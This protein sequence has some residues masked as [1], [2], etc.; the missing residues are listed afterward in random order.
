MLHASFKVA[1]PAQ[2]RPPNSGAGLVQVLASGSMPEP[3]VRE[4]GAVAL[5]LVHCPS[6]S[7]DNSCYGFAFK[8]H[9]SAY[10]VERVLQL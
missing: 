2:G 8:L 1:S 9:G 7:R 4:Q 6:T 5:Q 10:Q 3:Q